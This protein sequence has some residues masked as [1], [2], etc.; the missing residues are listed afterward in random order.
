MT[1]LH[2]DPVAPIPPVGCREEDDPGRLWSRRQAICRTVG[3]QSSLHRWAPDRSTKAFTA[4]LR[5]HWR[6]TSRPWSCGA[7]IG[8]VPPPAHHAISDP[9]GG[10]GRQHPVLTWGSS[11]FMRASS[12]ASALG[13]AMVVSSFAEGV[14]VLWLVW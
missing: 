1:F 5:T 12:G 13:M 6:C 10:R 7:Q 3:L 9:R 8:P 2:A 4:L 14:L 11:R